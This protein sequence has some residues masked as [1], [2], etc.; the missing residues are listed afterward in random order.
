MSATFFP[1]PLEI[2]AGRFR[3]L[4]EQYKIGLASSTQAPIFTFEA[5]VSLLARFAYSYSGPRMARCG[6]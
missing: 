6:T 3:L 1:H 5:D 2:E 4:A